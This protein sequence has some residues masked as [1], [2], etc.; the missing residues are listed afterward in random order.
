MNTDKP[1]AGQWFGIT[2][3]DVVSSLV[4]AVLVLAPAWGALR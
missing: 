4:A 1:T 2:R 3:C